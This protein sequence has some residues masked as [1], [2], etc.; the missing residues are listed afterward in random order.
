MP[1]FSHLE[2]RERIDH[3]IV[4]LSLLEIGRDGLPDVT[5]GLKAEVCA[6]NTLL[7]ARRVTPLYEL[8]QPVS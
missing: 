1:C 8:S 4:D 7:Q 3:S 6:A 5:C 2:G